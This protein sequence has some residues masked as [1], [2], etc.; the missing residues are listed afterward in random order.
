M[1]LL[2]LNRISA[3]GWNL[4]NQPYLHEGVPRVPRWQ[5]IANGPLLVSALHGH[6]VF[7]YKQS[8]T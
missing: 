5:C 3:D 4:P 8:M 2:I 1:L 6:T 7:W